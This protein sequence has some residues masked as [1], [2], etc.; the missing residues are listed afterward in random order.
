MNEIIRDFLTRD[1]E[2]RIS[3]N[4]LEYNY[5]FP[6]QE[7]R[8]YVS[9]V[10]DQPIS[11]ILDALSSKTKDTAATSNILLQFS[12]LDDA[13]NNLCAK[14]EEENNPGLTAEET[15]RL[16]LCDEQA[17]TKLAYRKYGE[18]HAKAAAALGIVYD[19]M[20][21]YFL[22]CVGMIYNQLNDGDRNKILTRLVLR[23][24]E[25]ALLYKKY[26]KQKIVNA[27]EFMS[28]L[29]DSTYRRR[30]SNLRR[31]LR[32]LADSKEYDFS[33]F[34]NSIVIE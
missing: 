13:T 11:E 30:R 26:S 16:L 21:V 18:N 8:D 19:V 3:E 15:G 32:V 17:K 33:E 5:E 12:S 34:L 25:I 4:L 10:I 24:D 9:R 2:N 6:E 7:V 27:R 29:S 28:V 14:I 20:N 31:L 1:Y 22:S 23:T